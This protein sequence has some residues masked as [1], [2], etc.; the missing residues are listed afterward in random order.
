MSNTTNPWENSTAT[1]ATNTAPHSTPPGDAWGSPAPS[2]GGA[3]WLHSAPA[4]QPEP[5]HIM[6]PFHKTLIPLD[7][8]VTDAIDWVVSHFRPVFQGIRVPVDF[9]LS[10]PDRPDAYVEVKSVTLSRQQGIAS[11]EV[12]SSM[13]HI[14]DLIEQNT[15]SA[16]SARQAANELLATSHEL[17]QLISSFELYRK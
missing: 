1:S 7:S 16:R 3:D 14:T 17:E 2:G 4:P 11:E 10:G 5:F 8:W 9:V 6:D 13:Q 12:A 15:A